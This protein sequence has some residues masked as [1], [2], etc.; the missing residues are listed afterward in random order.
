MIFPVTLKRFCAETPGEKPHFK[1]L[2][3]RTL[4]LAIFSD[5]IRGGLRRLAAQNPEQKRI[6]LHHFYFF[7]DGNPDLGS[8]W[9]LRRSGLFSYSRADI[10]I[11]GL[12][13]LSEQKI[14]E[15]MTPIRPI[16]DGFFETK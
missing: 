16:I 1:V 5:G 4:K 10:R 2:R 11:A 6:Y 9:T 14:K 7:I 15:I 13:A 12:P 3:I 8:C